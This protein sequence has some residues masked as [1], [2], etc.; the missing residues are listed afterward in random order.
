MDN[1][2][3]DRPYIVKPWRFDGVERLESLGF[4]I[5]SDSPPRGAFVNIPDGWTFEKRSN[6]IAEST[7]I[8]DNKGRRRVH[9]CHFFPV[10]R[11][12]EDDIFCI[13]TRYFIQRA[14]NCKTVTVVDRAD[15]TELFMV[16][17]ESGKRYKDA[18]NKCREFLKKNYPEW[19]DPLRYWD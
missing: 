7:T 3:E 1:T 13:D 12:V 10:K 5:I 16:E 8:Y 18:E 15:N 14:E 4:E 17:I 19:E 11:Y 9:F 6:Y 2:F